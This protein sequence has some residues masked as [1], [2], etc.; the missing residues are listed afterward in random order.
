[1][2]RNQVKVLIIG[3]STATSVDNGAAISVIKL[4]FKSGIGHKGMFK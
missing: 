3:I 1:M 4:A 2:L